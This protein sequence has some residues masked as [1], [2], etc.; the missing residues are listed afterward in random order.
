MQAKEENELIQFTSGG[1][2][3]RKEG[4]DA[5]ALPDL[6][7]RVKELIKCAATVGS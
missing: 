1:G 6:D 5:N 3:Q 2:E 4:F 7:R